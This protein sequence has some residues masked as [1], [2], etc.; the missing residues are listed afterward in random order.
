MPQPCL[1]HHPSALWHKA[2]FSSRIRSP[3]SSTRRMA[4]RCR[5]A[6]IVPIWRI[7]RCKAQKTSSDPTVNLRRTREM[8]IIVPR[9]GIQSQTKS[10]KS[11]GD[12]PKVAE[13]WSKRRHM[14]RASKLKERSSPKMLQTIKPWSKAVSLKDCHQTKD[15]MQCERRT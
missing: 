6:Q 9:Y 1:I 11:P 3:P 13:R 5:V 8:T 14:R 2:S 7:K 12:S 15:Q 4:R 10:G